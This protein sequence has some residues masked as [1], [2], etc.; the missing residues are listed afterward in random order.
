MS[1]T[2]YHKQMKVPY[3]VYADFECVLEKIEGCE[4]APDASFTLKT[5][6]NVPCGFSY[7]AVRSDGKLFGPFNHRGRDA[8]YVFLIWLQNHEREMRE[9]VEN[10]RPLFMTP[11]DWKNN[12]KATDC[13]IC[14]KSLFKD[15]FLDSISVYAPETGKYCGQSHRRCCFAAMKSFTG[16]RRE[17]Q[18]KDAIDLWIAKTQETCL[19]C[20]DPLLVANFRLSERPRPHDGEIPRGSTQRMQLQA[21]AERENSANTRNLPQPERL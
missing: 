5:E 20:A 7:I 4:P 18:P 2:N 15:L 16:P 12:R 9:D 10:K 11:E 14:N 19:F 1:F 21:K 17:R 8:V 13:H 6:R 3:V